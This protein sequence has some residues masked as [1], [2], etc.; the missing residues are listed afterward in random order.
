MEK[1]EAECDGRPHSRIAGALFGVVVHLQQA[2]P[3]VTDNLRV[4]NLRRRVVGLI[5]VEAEGGGR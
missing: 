4:V 2:R 3:A 1:R 5:I